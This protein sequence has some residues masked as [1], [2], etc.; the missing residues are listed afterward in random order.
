MR[1]EGVGVLLNCYQKI[2]K[3]DRLGT[4]STRLVGSTTS[5]LKVEMVDFSDISNFFMDPDNCESSDC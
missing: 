5:E 1:F 3:Y 2:I 4:V